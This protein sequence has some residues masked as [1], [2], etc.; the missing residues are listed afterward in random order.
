[1]VHHRQP[2]FKVFN[3]LDAQHRP[4]DFRISHRHAGLYMVKNRGPDIKS[5][6]IARNLD[7]TAVQHQTGALLQ[8]LFNPGQHGLFV[9]RVHHRSHGRGF[10]VGRSHGDLLRLLHNGLNQGVGD[11]LLNHHHRQGHAALARAAEGRV[12]DSGRGPFHR[13]ILQHQRVVFGLAESLNP[14]AGRGGRGV[15]VFAHAGG[16]HEGDSLHVRVVEENLSLG[17]GA[18]DDVDHA[19]GKPRLLVKLRDAH[20]GLRR[21]GG[22]LQHDGISAGDAHGGHPAHRNHGREVKGHDPGKH[23]QRFPVENRVVTRGGIHQALPHHQG[24]SGNR[25]LRGLLGLEHVP[26]GLLPGLSVFVSHQIGQLIHVLHQQVPQLVENLHPFHHRRGRPAGIGLP[27]AR[28]GIL[29]FLLRAAG[30]FCDYLPGTW[31]ICVHILLG[32][33]NNVLA[34]RIESQ[35]FCL[36]HHVL[37]SHF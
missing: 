37:L 16:P 9:S 18:G 30:N 22:G 25:L 2:L 26:L 24:R 14:L 19:V 6:F 12:D 31:I 10:L 11:A 36:S 34:V 33:G 20:A 8:T 32:F 27:G 21:E 4:E 5:V 35:S 15:D 1:M 29:H 3:P 7:V 17:A 28:D 23:S 13:S